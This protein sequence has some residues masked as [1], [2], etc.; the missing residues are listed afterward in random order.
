MSTPG[1]NNIDDDKTCPLWQLTVDELFD[2]PHQQ[3]GGFPLFSMNINGI[4]MTC[5]TCLAVMAATYVT[6]E[7]TRNYSQVDKLWSIVPVVYAWILVC[8]DRTLLMAVLATV[9][10]CRLTW[11]FSRRGGYTWPPWRGDEDYRWKYLQEGFLWDGLQHP[12]IWKLFNLFF[13]SIYQNLL[14][15]WIATPSV[16][17]HLAAKKCQTVYQQSLGVLDGVASIM[18][19]SLVVMETMADNQ[20]YR[21]Q[22]EKHLN[23]GAA[24]KDGFNQSGLFAIVRKPNYACEQALWIVFYVFSFSCFS[25]DARYQHFINWSAIGCTMLVA[26]FQGSGYFTEKITLSKYPNYKEYM[27]ET[28]LYVPNLFQLFQ[29]DSSK[30]QR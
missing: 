6:S 14:L 26:L 24:C 15:L 5:L 3:H 29:R 25:N 23:G 9:W 17:A 4:Q 20:Q 28:P 21:F 12:V 2:R 1:D 13:I 27:K 19:L 7:V 16:I 10:G 18:Y 11:N 8:D 30:K 22:Q